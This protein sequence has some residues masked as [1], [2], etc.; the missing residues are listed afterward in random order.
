[1][2]NKSTFTKQ[3]CKHLL[4]A[5]SEWGLLIG[6]KPDDEFSHEKLCAL[7]DKLRAGAGNVSTTKSTKK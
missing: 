1:M 2:T 6:A 4:R 5:V 3:E 7:I